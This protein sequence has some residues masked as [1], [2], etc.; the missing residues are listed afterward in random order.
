MNDKSEKRKPQAKPNQPEEL[1]VV[2]QSMGMLGAEVIKGK[3]ESAG[4]PAVLKYES[5][6]TVF[7]VVG[8]D[9]GEVKVLV[10]KSHEQ[11]ALEILGET[12]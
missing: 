8:G 11:E 6:S 1:V 7:P 5:A 2:Y 9:M 3:L 12:T 4:I 10:S